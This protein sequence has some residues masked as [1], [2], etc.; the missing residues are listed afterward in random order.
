MLY[1]RIVMGSQYEHSHLSLKVSSRVI[2]TV[3]M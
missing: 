3:L 1:F 2:I